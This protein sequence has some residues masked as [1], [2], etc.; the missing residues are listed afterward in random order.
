MFVL[1]I[2]QSRKLEQSV[3]TYWYFQQE[4]DLEHENK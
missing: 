4:L 3:P 2:W 1:D